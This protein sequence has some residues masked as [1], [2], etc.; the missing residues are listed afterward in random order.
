MMQNDGVL[1]IR[2]LKK[3]VLKSLQESGI[4]KDETE[5]DNILEQKVSLSKEFY[6]MP[7]LLCLP[8]RFYF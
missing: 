6:F 3:L 2:K 8:F 4:A 1:K 7:P 5:L